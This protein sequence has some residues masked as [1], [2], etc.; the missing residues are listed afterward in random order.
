MPVGFAQLS[1]TTCLTV[2]VI[3]VCL[4]RF[5]LW[6]LPKPFPDIPYN[7]ESTKRLLGDAPDMRKAIRETQEFNTWCAE[8]NEKHKSALVQVFVEPFSKPW[9]LLSDPAEAQDILLRRPEFDRSNFIINRMGPLGHFQARFKTNGHWKMSREWVKDLMTPRYLENYVGPGINGAVLSLLK[10]WEEK[11]RLANGRPFEAADDLND[12]SLDVM[13]S[14]SFGKHLGQTAL[15][16]QIDLLPQI[17]PGKIDAGSL[18]DPAHFPNAPA[19]DFVSAT[20]KSTELTEDI[21]NSWTP[22][23]ALWWMRQKSHYKK[24]FG[25]T[26]RIVRQQVKASLQRLAAGSAA[27]TAIDHMMMREKSHAAKLGRSPISEGQH[28]I[29]E[30]FGD[31]FAGHHTTGAALAWIVKFMGEHP[32]KQKNLRSALYAAYPKAV[33]EGRLPSYEEMK[34]AKPAYL[35]AFVEEAL[36]LH[37][38]TVTR[39]A[40]RDTIVLGHH[41]PKGT[42]IFLNSN[43]PGF[44]SPSFPVDESKRSSTVKKVG[45]WDETKDMRAFEPERWLVQRTEGEVEFDATAGPQLIFGLG[46]RGCWGKKLAYIEMRILATLVCWNFDMAEPPESLRSQAAS[47]G[48]SHKAQQ[49]YV[50]P[51]KRESTQT[52]V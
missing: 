15:G 43:G 16:P 19:H 26:E 41:V 40:Q 31:M 30:V 33:E 5:Y 38:T 39:E 35:E 20:H 14:F 25:N 8:Q 49:C 21:V 48:I 42:I 52:P 4:Y 22:R 24:A 36:R 37:A 29:D 3:S 45:G 46:P 28:M 47:D 18:D 7:V 11:S 13:L 17:E 12:C 1:T 50:R 34:R 51:R 2:A 6:L 10:V 9:L 44:Y 23:L 27:V 32:E